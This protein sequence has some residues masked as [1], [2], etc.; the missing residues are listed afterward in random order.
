MTHVPLPELISNPT[1]ES[2]KNGEWGSGSTWN[3]NRVPD[4]TDDVLVVHNVTMGGMVSVNAIRAEGSLTLSSDFVSLRVGTI[5]VMPN[6]ALLGGSVTDPVSGTITFKETSLG[7]DNWGCGLV[8]EGTC[9]LFGRHVPK[10]HI[11]IAKRPLA[12]DSFIAMREIPHGWRVGDRVLLPDSSLHNRMHIDGHVEIDQ[13]RTISA[14]TDQGIWLDEPL[15]Y[16]PPCPH[17]YDGSTKYMGY[18]VNMTTSL[19]LESKSPSGVRSHSVYAGMA[20]VILSGVGY[21]DMGRTHSGPIDEGNPIGKYAVHFHHC[22]GPI[23]GDEPASGKQFQMTGCVVERS[24]KWPITIHGDSSWGS[25]DN[26]VV[27]DSELDGIAT[28]NGH[29]YM[30]KV[31]RNFIGFIRAGSGI[32]HYSRLCPTNDNVICGALANANGRDGTGGVYYVG[33]LS[34]VFPGEAPIVMTN[35]SISVPKFPGAHHE[36]D[37]LQITPNQMPLIECRGNEAYASNGCVALDHLKN[38]PWPYGNVVYHLVQD[39]ILWNCYGPTVAAYDTHGT[40]VDGI[41]CRTSYGGVYDGGSIT[42]FHTIHRRADVF[43]EV[44]NIGHYAA[45]DG[46]GTIVVEDSVFISPQPVFVTQSFPGDGLPSDPT[47]IEK[48]VL[49]RNVKMVSTTGGPLITVGPPNQQPP[50]PI[51]VKVEDDV[52]WGNNYT[53]AEVQ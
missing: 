11:A 18:I 12:N 51:S 30:T 40:I 27:W 33:L 6:G 22:M 23:H 15:T 1:I 26:N 29:E 49:L 38:Q 19:V 34:R 8:V 16:T 20:D 24:T 39:S 17:E 3:L 32:W 50:S 47:A 13:F 52:T 45:M 44:N 21:Q 10:R 2:V 37:M 5:Q 31:E 35:E 41:V 42:D 48:K 28:E 14:V 25:V 46:E 36:E 7:T 9:K 53:V 43:A 4:A